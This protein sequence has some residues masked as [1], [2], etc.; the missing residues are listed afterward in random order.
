MRTIIS[1]GIAF[2]LFLAATAPG[3]AQSPTPES[4]A[5]A[6]ELVTTIRME[7]QAAKMLPIVIQALKPAIV[8]NR[9]EVERDFNA[10]IPSI[11]D[12]LKQNWA[13]YVDGCAIIYARH[14]TAGE[15]QE[16]TAFYRT[17]T[18]RKVISSLPAV[19][20]ETVSFGTRFGQILAGDLQNRFK[21]ELR[22]KGH[23]I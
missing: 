13:Q 2:A 22:K 19:T 17:A 23:D 18:G 7:E 10:L 8:Q 1:A 3:S 11:V 15:L 5:A 20:Q 6:K 14:F 4:L 12:L 16:M 9:P 21:E